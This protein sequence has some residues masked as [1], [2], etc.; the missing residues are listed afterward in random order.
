MACLSSPGMCCTDRNTSNNLKLVNLKRCIPGDVE[1]SR[2]VIYI[3]A[4]CDKA[5]RVLEAPPSNRR[6]SSFP[7]LVRYLNLVEY[8]QQE[9]LYNGVN[10]I[11][12]S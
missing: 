12:N 8:R 6:T 7:L 11:H 10:G 4:S 9:N 5:C 1:I 2:T 3:P